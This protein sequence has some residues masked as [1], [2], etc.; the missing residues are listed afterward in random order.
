MERKILYYLDKVEH[1]IDGEGVMPVTCEIDPT[2][3]CQL[4]CTFCM[5][6]TLRDKT[7]SSENQEKFDL[8]IGLYRYLLLDLKK[9]GVQSITFT[10]GGEPT[11]HKDFDKMVEFAEMLG[12]EYGLVTNGLLVD[13]IERPD[14]F[15]F[16]RVSLDAGTSETYY[17]LKK[18][19]A[20]DK[21]VNNIKYAIDKGALVGT[22]FVVNEINRNDIQAAQELA[23][24]LGV[25]YIQF[26]PAWENGKP[27]EDYEISGNKVVIDTKRYIAVDRTPCHIAGLIGV[28]GAD[29]RVYY[30]CQYRGDQRYCL[31]DLRHATF[32][33]I[34]SRRPALVPDIERCPNCRYMNYTRAY[35]NATEGGTLFFQHKNFL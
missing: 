25:A 32:P 26:K 15:K 13:K 35:K 9:I 5:Y 7:Q 27:Y 10:G 8:D 11:L 17:N 2:N 29:A 6:R 12:F 4:N 16:I 34:W 33:E 23:N 19:L 14:K 3:R 24:E 20:F 28:V 31:G 1:L 21:V 30:C 18:A 22:S